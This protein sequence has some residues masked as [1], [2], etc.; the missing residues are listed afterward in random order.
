M[1]RRRRSRSR[2]PSGFYHFENLYH[3]SVSGFGDGDFIRL[4]DEFGNVWRGSA[5]MEDDETIRYRF[6]DSTGRTISGM[7]DRFGILLR[8]DR[9]QTWRG[10]VF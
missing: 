5:E 10:Y 3:R 7:S 1:I 9:G 2:A 8:D 4:K 6:R